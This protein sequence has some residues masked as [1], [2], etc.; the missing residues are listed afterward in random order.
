MSTAARYGFM[1]NVFLSPFSLTILCRARTSGLKQRVTRAA[2]SLNPSWNRL[3]S[4]VTEVSGSVT[5][6]TPVRLFQDTSKRWL[7]SF[8]S[9]L[10]LLQGP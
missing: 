5:S 6:V 8:S 9:S 4:D 10:E 3:V 7:V 2:L 1:G